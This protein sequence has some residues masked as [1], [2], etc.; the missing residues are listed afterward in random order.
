MGQ[1]PEL[2]NFAVV[3]RIL[4]VGAAVDVEVGTTR[5]AV[6]SGTEKAITRPISDGSA[7]RRM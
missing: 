1:D 7:A 3:D 5:V 6:S 2:D 4:E